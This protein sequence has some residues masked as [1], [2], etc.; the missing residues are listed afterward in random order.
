MKKILFRITFPVLIL[1]LFSTSYLPQ[2]KKNTIEIKEGFVGMIGY[3][4]LMSVK[5][6]EQT[7]EHKYNDSL[8]QVHLINYIRGWTYFRP[9]ND[10]QEKSTEDSRYYG[11][12]L[13]GNDSI[14]FDGMVN[15]NIEPKEKSKINCILYFISEED[16]LKFDKREF[17]YQKVDV[18]DQIEEYNF[19]GG[20]VY[21]YEHFP[22]TKDGS[23][24]DINKYILVK[25]YV[26]FITSAC[27]SIGKIFR[28]E[29][30]ESTNPPTTQIVP[31]D[32]IVWK[33]GE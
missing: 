13:Q 14:A 2:Q 21:V 16:L 6:L 12:I 17:G 25:N 8:Y 20:K 1:F 32:K 24:I 7:L 3:G 30:D 23:K 11:F 19:I 22:E 33:K 10:P 28:T 5:S 4:T 9:I 31:Y 29:F 15:L 26:D 18:T 27:D